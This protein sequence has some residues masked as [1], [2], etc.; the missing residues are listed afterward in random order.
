MIQIAKPWTIRWWWQAKL[1][2]GKPFVRILKAHAQLVAL[3]SNEDHEVKLTT[4]VE[5]YTS[6]GASGE[7]CVHR[8]RLQCFSL[9]LADTKY[10]NDVSGQW[11][12]VWPLDTLVDSPIFRWRRASFLPM[13][14]NESV[15]CPEPEEDKASNEAPLHEL[16]SQKSILPSAP[17]SQ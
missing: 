12:N 11:Y 2:N 7:C 5:R 15:E 3:Q 10:Q 6:Q 4:H 9:V 1:A 17:A 13:L 8:W 14:F 16:E